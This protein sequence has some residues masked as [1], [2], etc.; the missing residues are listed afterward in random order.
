MTETEKTQI[1]LGTSPMFS[2]ASSTTLWATAIRCT[3][4]APHFS[5]T[6]H[7][8]LAAA[9]TKTRGCHAVA[10]N[11][12]PQVSQRGS[13]SHRFPITFHYRC[14]TAL[15][16]HRPPHMTLHPTS[17][18]NIK[19]LR[20]EFCGR[21]TWKFPTN[22]RQYPVPRARAVKALLSILLES[23]HPLTVVHD[24]LKH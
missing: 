23:Q 24:N 19:P 12:H 22:D 10:V 18:L 2:Q 3:E 5:A 13:Q 6:L 4:L 11:S 8:L 21:D 16:N 7:H 1:C 20:S 14:L 17:E 15:A 9:L